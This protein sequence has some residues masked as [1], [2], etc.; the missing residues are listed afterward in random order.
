[1]RRRLRDARARRRAR[2]WLTRPTSGSARRDRGS[3]PRDAHRAPSRRHALPPRAQ[4]PEDA[5]RGG[6]GLPRLSSPRACDPDR[7]RRGPQ[8]RAADDGRRACRA[9]RRT[10]RASVRRAGGPRARRGA[11]EAGHRARDVYVTNVVKH[12]KCEERG[13]RRI[14]QT[15]SAPRSTHA[16]RG[17]TRSSSGRPEGARLPRGHR[18]AGAARAELPRHAGRGERSTPTWRGR[19]RDGASVGDP[20]RA[21]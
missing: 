18:G 15:P 20:A 8:A 19:D 21:R 5:A 17:S 11:R 10:G 4:E 3:P 7:L 16:C 9:T 13:K 1:M 6:R 2:H 12:F 14:H